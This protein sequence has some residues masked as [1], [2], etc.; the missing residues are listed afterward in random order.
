[1]LRA[2]ANDLLEHMPERLEI[3]EDTRDRL[4]R[5]AWAYWADSNWCE[6][7]PNTVPTVIVEEGRLKVSFGEAPEG[8]DRDDWRMREYL[9]SD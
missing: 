9:E 5:A 6:E 7:Y 3:D 1:M 4:K 2:I 8:G